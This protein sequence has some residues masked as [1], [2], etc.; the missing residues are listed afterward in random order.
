MIVQQLTVKQQKEIELRLDTKDSF[1][2]FIARF[3]T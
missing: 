2:L 1:S 3:L